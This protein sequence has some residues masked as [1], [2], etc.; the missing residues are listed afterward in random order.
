MSDPNETAEAE[1]LNYPGRYQALASDSKDHIVCEK[2]KN[3]AIRCKL[4]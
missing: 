3:Y 4:I 2:W 1:R